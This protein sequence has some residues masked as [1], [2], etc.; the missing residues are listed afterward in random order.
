MSSTTLQTINDA[1][2]QWNQRGSVS[3]GVI[4]RATIDGTGNHIGRSQKK[5]FGQGPKTVLHR[6]SSSSPVHLSR[7]LV[8]D[9]SCYR[10]E[11]LRGCYVE[12]SRDQYG[13]RFLQR[14][15]EVAGSAVLQLVFE[16]V[17]PVISNLMVDAYGNYVV[18]K[19]FDF[20]TDYQKKILASKL[21]GHVFLLS[22][23]SYGCRVIQK[24]LDSIPS[25][26]QVGVCHLC[27][28]F[29][30]VCVCGVHACVCVCNLSIVYYCEVN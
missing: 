5:T 3:T 2:C 27:A 1:L 10:L 4:T 17:L 9:P 20:G 18:Q 12:F 22:T 25:Y 28:F 8:E 29:F 16:E 19:F 24:A 23:H 6:P 13:S 14:E 30:F 7:L 15:M 11:D 26:Y 21:Q